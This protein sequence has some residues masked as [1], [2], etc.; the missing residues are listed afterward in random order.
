MCF[1]QSNA[2]LT[3]VSVPALVT[4]GGDLAFQVLSLP[5]FVLA[6]MLFAR[7]ERREAEFGVVW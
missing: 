3:S 6:I 7:V 2:K 5:L 1:C 4:V